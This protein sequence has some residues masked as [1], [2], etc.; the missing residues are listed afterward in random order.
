MA[1]MSAELP[2]FADTSSLDMRAE[3]REAADRNDHDRIGGLLEVL[4]ADIDKSGLAEMARRRE[5]VGRLIEAMEELAQDAGG[6]Y[7]LGRL[8]AVDDFLDRLRTRALGARA[9]NQR[10]RHAETVRE[11]VLRLMESDGPQRPRDAARQLNVD[12]TQVSRA[13]RQLQDEDLIERSGSPRTGDRRAHIYVL[14]DAS[15]QPVGAGAC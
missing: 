3:L 4:L 1:N 13:L 11:Q 5:R 15:P 2:T 12:P 7:A 14:R 10:Q 6:A 8:H 9:Q